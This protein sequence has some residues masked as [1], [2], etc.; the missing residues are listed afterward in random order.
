M[1]FGGQIMTRRNTIAILV[2]AVFAE[3]AFSINPP[4]AHRFSVALVI[5]LSGAASVLGCRIR[6]GFMLATQERDGHAGQESDGHLGGLDVYVSEIDG[7][8]DV[9]IE[10]GRIATRGDVDIVVA[11]GSEKTRILIGK[12]LVGSRIALLLPGRSPF[13]NSGL[14]AV[15]KFV[16]AYENEYGGAPSSHAAQGYHAARRIDVAV[17]D[18][19]GV[20]DTASLRRSFMETER[21]LDW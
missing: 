14:P 6:N 13:P 11:F 10:V 21:G 8:G 5:P 2:L 16:A 12:I 3:F 9:A 17:R 18:Q 20:R 7:N 15:A 19:S 4:M 1:R